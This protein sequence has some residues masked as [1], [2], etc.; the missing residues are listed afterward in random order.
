MKIVHLCL[1]AFYPDNHS[2]QENMLPKFHKKLG[3]DVEVIASQETFDE[4]GY[5]SYMNKVGSYQNEY[6]IK[7]TRLKYRLPHK[8]NHKL[9][10]Y[11]GVYQTLEEA[12]PNIIFI[13]N[14]QFLSIYTVIRYIK[15]NPKIRV[16]VDNHVDFSNSAKN[17]VSKN[18]LHK[19][20]W[21]QCAQ[22]INKY[23][24]KFYGVL[25]ARVNFLV[26]I[27]KLPEKKVELLVMGADDE[28]VLE[29]KK[30]GTRELIRSQYGVN[31]SDFLIM[32]GGKIDASKKQVLLL[33]KAV[34]EIQNPQIK[35]IVFGS[36]TKDLKDSVEN[37]CKKDKVQ[38]IGWIKAE[39]SYKIWSAADLACFP[40]RHSVFWEQVAGMGIP[41]VCKFWDGTTHVDFGGNVRFLYNDSAEEI[42]SVLKIIIETKDEYKKMKIAAEKCRKHFS[43]RCIAA[44]SIEG[45][46]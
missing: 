27:Y 34:N 4:N 26:D 12:K 5:I 44:K 8:L 43:Y 23:A 25:P 41:M 33:M 20:L 15:I 30:S 11:K 6:D 9:K 13:H 2:Y 36:T 7:V 18:L 38:Y 10:I 31:A 14:C 35:L 16:Y 17:W 29:V 37:Y 19:I 40:G 39:E 1:G 21:R 28:K 45:E 22:S 32:F 24:I 46:E 42:K 3:F